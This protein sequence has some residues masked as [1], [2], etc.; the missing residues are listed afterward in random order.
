[1][2]QKRNAGKDTGS[3][4]SKRIKRVTGSRTPGISV[5]A[6]HLEEASRIRSVDR[7]VLDI[8]IQVQ[9][10]GIVRVYLAIPLQRS[11]VR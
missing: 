11:S 8:R 3:A 1:G 7:V 10:L 4:A 6:D 5:A 2:T 9:G